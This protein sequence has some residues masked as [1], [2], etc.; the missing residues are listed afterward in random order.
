[1]SI[2]DDEHLNVLL[3]N[4][5]GY[6]LNDEYFNLTD[7]QEIEKKNVMGEGF[8]GGGVYQHYPLTP[9]ESGKKC[10]S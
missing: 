10:S 3:D 1:L 4:D 5:N 6:D 9:T 7:K 2:V 8:I